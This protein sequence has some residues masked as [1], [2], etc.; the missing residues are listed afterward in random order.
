MFL[1]LGGTLDEDEDGDELTQGGYI[2]GLL[3]GE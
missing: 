3:V 1:L 2:A